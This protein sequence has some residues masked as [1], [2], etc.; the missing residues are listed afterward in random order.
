[1]SA[2]I[3]GQGRRVSVSAPLIDLKQALS[4][5]LVGKRSDNSQYVDGTCGI[6]A[7]IRYDSC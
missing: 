2:L 6:T 1:M 3:G 5:V 4:D 7:D